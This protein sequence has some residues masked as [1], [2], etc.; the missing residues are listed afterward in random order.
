LDVP[1]SLA[2]ELVG[3]SWTRIK[4][5][6]SGG[7]V[8]RLHGKRNFPDL[9]LKHGVGKI[10]AEIMDEAVRLKWLSERLPAPGVRQFVWTCKEAWLLMTALPGRTAYD[11]LQTGAD[12]YAI[13][14]AI[15]AYLRRLH[16]IPPSECPFNSALDYRLARGRERIDSGLVDEDDFDEERAGWTAEQVWTAMQQHLPFTSDQVVT[17]GDFSLDNLLVSNGEVIGCI[18]AGKLGIA[19]RYQDIAILWNGLEEFGEPI[20]DRLLTAYGI[21]DPDRGKLQFH[22]L[23]D[24]LF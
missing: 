11:L 2:P 22:L 21:P 13:V 16:A 20:R 23:L 10:A 6:Q 5:G 18:D 12:S 4:T 24:E 1:L 19:D 14:D 9:V 15:A 17:H 7:A 8:Y 3:Y